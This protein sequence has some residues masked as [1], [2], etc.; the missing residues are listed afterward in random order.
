MTAETGAFG[1]LLKTL[2]RERHLSQEEMAGR[3]GSTQRHISFLETGRAEP[4][5]SML[6]RIERELGLPI[7]KA[8]VLYQTA[9]FTSP[10]KH[11]AEDSP[12]V[13]EALD[14]IETRL[15]ANWPFPGFLL[16]KRWTILRSN[17]PGR[18]FLENL[19]M[20]GNEPP[21]L[22]RIFLSDSFRKRVLNWS[23]AAPIFAAR[24][25][26][27]AAEDP[28]MAALLDN[29]RQ[30]GLLDGLTEIFREDIP[31]FVPVE[32]LGPD[33]SALRLTS[34]IGQLASVQDAVIEGM[35]IELMVPMDASSENTLLQAGAGTSTPQAAE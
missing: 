9:G 2:R 10:Y 31:V 25:Y 3:L 19:E 34:L 7:G 30:A 13:L 14:L 8:Q 20:H 23:E 6:Q 35:T 18:S 17:I 5:R 16:D 1:N 26:R 27:K 11:R 21:N 29:A 22:F 4:S 33:G 12:D 24:L 15:L 28:E 32:V